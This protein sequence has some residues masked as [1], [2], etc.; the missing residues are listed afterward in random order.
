[1]KRTSILLFGAGFLTLAIAAA[2]QPATPKIQNVPIQRTSATSGS[3]MYSTY[4]AVCH[5]ADGKGNGPAAPS[6]KTH[7]SDLT[8][9]SKKNG[10]NFPSA[11]VASILQFGVENPA[12]GNKEMPIWGDLF[13]TLNTSGRGTSGPTRLRISNLTDYLKTIQQK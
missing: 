11:H 3:E 2:Q 9:L 5:G 7:P 6:L 12:H 8:V 1:M 10:G 13:Q 4:C